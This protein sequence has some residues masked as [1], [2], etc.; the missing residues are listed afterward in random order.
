MNA[1]GYFV[2]VWD[3]DPNL[4]GL[5]DIHARLFDPNGVPLGDQFVVNTFLDGAQCNPQVA[6]NDLAEFVVVWETQVDPNITEREIFGQYFNNLGEPVGDEFLINAYVEGDQRYPSVAI[7]GAGRFVT[8]WQSDGQDGSR[9]GIFG[10][11]GQITNQ[12]V[13]KY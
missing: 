11:V 8:V 9:Y 2:V 4:A 3:G 13:T 6:M 10:E 5:D 1:H 12:G 7:S